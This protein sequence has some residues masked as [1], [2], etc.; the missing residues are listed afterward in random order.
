MDLTQSFVYTIGMDPEE[1]VRY[2]RTHTTGVLSLARDGKPYAVPVSYV[3][4]EGGAVF[5]RLSD[6]GRSRKLDFLAESDAVVFLV[7]DDDDA[8]EDDAA[9]VSLRG[10][11]V[12]VDE[13]VVPDGFGALHVFD[14]DV[15]D[16]SLRYFRL[17]ETERIARRACR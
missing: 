5:V 8:S 6:D 12:E 17:V 16:L 15:D 1:T 10:Q 11:L 3:A 13:S 7:Y 9:S 14:E 2:L 4:D